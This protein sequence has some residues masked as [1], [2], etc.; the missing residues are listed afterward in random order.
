MIAKA[1][2]GLG[3]G[4]VPPA[5]L[6]PPPTGEEEVKDSQKEGGVESVEDKD[7]FGGGLLSTGI[8]VYEVVVKIGFIVR[9]SKSLNINED[10]WRVS[11]H[12]SLPSVN[13]T[14]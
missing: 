4:V 9:A 3:G 7:G 1:L 12:H 2:K 14:P 10:C 13:I 5:G 8:I 6:L 11:K